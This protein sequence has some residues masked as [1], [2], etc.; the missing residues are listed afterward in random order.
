ME[1]EKKKSNK[2]L[3]III[4]IALVLLIIIGYSQISKVIENNQINNVENSVYGNSSVNNMNK[5]ILVEDEDYIYYSVNNYRDSYY[6]FKKSKKDD[7][8]TELTTAKGRYLNLYN[9]QLY[10]I[11]DDEHAIFK[12]NKDGSNRERVL[13]R[14]K[15]MYIV[16]DYLYYIEGD[17][18]YNNLRR[19][20][21]T[22]NKVKAITDEDVKEFTIY[23][24]YIYYISNKNNQLYKVNL[25]GKEKQSI[26]TDKVEH[27]C[28]LDDTIY[29]SNITDGNAIYG[30]SLDGKENKKILS[31]ENSLMNLYIIVNNEIGVLEKKIS[32]NYICWY[33]MEGTSTKNTSLKELYSGLGV[34]F[35]N[36]TTF[37]VYDNNKILINTDYKRSVFEEIKQD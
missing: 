24:K 15:A 23:D 10:Y 4:G 7:S 3:F 11:N 21:L 9:N 32:S 25:L 31:M 1:Q 33:D 20:D 30:I 34:Y 5:G 17:S 37:G 29:V 22:T 19:L 12:M 27:I 35:P 13:D 6:I 26:F 16:N 14:A 28:I 18:F 2:K 8:K 36:L